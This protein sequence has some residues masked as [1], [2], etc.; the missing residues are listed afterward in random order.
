MAAAGVTL[1]VLLGL[2]ACGLLW[3]LTRHVGPP[4]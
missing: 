3:H 2:L 4:R 1:L